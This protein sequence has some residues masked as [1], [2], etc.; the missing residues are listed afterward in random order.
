MKM[1]ENPNIPKPTGVYPIL[2][3]FYYER[4]ITAIEK[5]YTSDSIISRYVGIAVRH[6][7]FWRKLSMVE[8]PST[9]L[10]RKLFLYL[11]EVQAR[12][13]A[14]LKE[15][16]IAAAVDNDDPDKMGRAFARYYPDIRDEEGDTTKDHIPASRLEAEL[17]RAGVPFNAG[18]LDKELLDSN[19]NNTADQSR[20]TTLSESNVQQIRGPAFSAKQFAVTFYPTYC[21]VDFADWHR[22][23]LEWATALQYGLPPAEHVAAIVNRDGGK[24]T[25]AEIIMTYVMASGRRGYGVYLSGTQRQANDHVTNISGLLQS[26]SLNAQ[27]PSVG[28]VALD[29]N[30]RSLGWKS[31]R[32]TSAAGFTIDAIG[33]DTQIRGAKID[34]KRIDFIIIDDIDSDNDTPYRVETKIQALGR[35]ILPA[36]SGNLAV[37]AVQNLITSYSIFSR[38]KAGNMDVLQARV[39]G[40]VPAV[41]DLKTNPENPLT[42]YASEGVKVLDG[43]PSW[44]GFSLQKAQNIIN[45]VGI[46]NFLAEYQHLTDVMGG[47]AFAVH[48]K[49]QFVEVELDNNPPDGYT[50]K[51][52]Y[53]YGSKRPY[54][55]IWYA[56]ADGES[57]ILIN[58]S[59]VIPPKGTIFILHELY[60]WIG[61]PNIG[62]NSSSAEHVESILNEEATLPYRNRIEDGPADG[63]IFVEPDSGHSIAEIHRQHGITW[64][65]ADRSQGSRKIG[66]EKLREYLSNTIDRA[67]GMVEREGPCFYVSKKCENVIRTVPNLPAD[68]RPDKDGDVDTTSEDH[69]WDCVRYAIL[70]TSN[71]EQVKITR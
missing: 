22:E 26:K 56:V 68:N 67:V 59:M 42:E 7:R 46:R 19:I 15:R 25:I 35:K 65:A 40:P 71:I 62:D 41:Y 70:D 16:H 23:L 54:A 53:D 47:I 63:S 21:S 11:N 14:E 28:E 45:L 24:S 58:D 13:A 50:I 55:C 38:L 31:T 61:E 33:I 9:D 34:E 17:A 27:Y 57:E 1:I 69:L 49:K 10:H 60:G 2:D 5:G 36:G 8:G 37:L 51:R 18:L 44:E 32:I 30:N 39:I 43:R 48:W 52:C 64:V 4:A 29:K 3:R 66:A 12:K 6:F 20:A